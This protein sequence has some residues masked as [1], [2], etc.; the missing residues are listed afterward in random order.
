MTD[1]RNQDSRLACEF[2]KPVS[3]M[4]RWVAARAGER[5]AERTEQKADGEAD[6]ESAREPQRG[7]PSLAG[8]WRRSLQG[9][10]KA[11]KSWRQGWQGGD[12]EGGTREERLSSRQNFLAGLS[13]CPGKNLLWG[14]WKMGRNRKPCGETA[15]G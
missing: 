5:G 8:V 14:N 6:L 9:E 13:L 15:A 3:E 4:E 11:G 2:P 12:E 1:A 10:A 7:R